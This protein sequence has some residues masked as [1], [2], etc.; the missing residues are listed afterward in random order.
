MMMV[1]STTVHQLFVAWNGA[2]SD[3]TPLLR[4]FRVLSVAP[5]ESESTVGSKVQ[6]LR[7]NDLG[8]LS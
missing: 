1:V 3:A 4:A 2:I 6:I 8:A 7:Q 5:T